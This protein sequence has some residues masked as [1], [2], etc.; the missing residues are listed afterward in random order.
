MRRVISIAAATAVAAAA[1]ALAG[2]AGCAPSNGTGSISSTGTGTG[3]T[4]TGSTG[5]TTSTL[6]LPHA[7]CGA[8]ITHDVSASTR[9]LRADRGALTCFTTAARACKAA[10]LDVTQMGVDTGTDWVF[11]IASGG[12]PGRCTVIAYSQHYS[13][14]GIGGLFTQAPSGN[15]VQAVKT[16]NCQETAVTSAGVTLNC[17]GQAIEIPATVNVHKE[18]SVPTS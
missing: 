1:A 7:S 10:S 11:A 15:W 13:A 2:I 4:S 3:S 6:T 16:A 9:L 17:Q 14:T 8:A 18:G 5:G 12:T